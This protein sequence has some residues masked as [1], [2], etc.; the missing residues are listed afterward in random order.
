MA[1]GVPSAKSPGRSL[2]STSRW[3]SSMRGVIR[4]IFNVAADFIG[5]YV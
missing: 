5:Q 4:T 2:V 3:E 1:M